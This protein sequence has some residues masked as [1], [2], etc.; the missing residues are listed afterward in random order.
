MIKKSINLNL[1]DKKKKTDKK[2][3]LDSKKNQGTSKKN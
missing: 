1:I 3:R 2:P